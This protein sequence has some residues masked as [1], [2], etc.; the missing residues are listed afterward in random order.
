MQCHAYGKQGIRPYDRLTL[1]KRTLQPSGIR[2]DIY[3]FLIIRMTKLWYK[4]V[5]ERVSGGARVL[6]VGI[7]TA[8][9]LVRNKESLERKNIVVVGIDYEVPPLLASL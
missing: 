7:G 6:D 5:L 1:Y 8:T 4:T 9:A 2:A 3:D